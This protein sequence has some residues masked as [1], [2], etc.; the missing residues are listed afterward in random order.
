MADFPKTYLILAGLLLLLLAVGGPFYVQAQDIP[1]Q[2]ALPSA[3]AV[4]FEAALYLM[5]AFPALRERVPPLVTVLT[6]PLIY[7]LYSVPAEVFAARSCLLLLVMG[8]IATYWFRRLPPH[9]ASDLGFLILMAA[10]LAADI[11]KDIYARPHP[12][13]RLS[14]LG[15]MFWIR[16]GVLAVL[17]SRPQSGIAFGFLP[18]KE[19]WA[20]GLRWFA[21][22]LPVVLVG[23]TVSGFARFTPPQREWWQVAGIAV[24]YF[25]G[26]LWV[27]ALSEEFFF[28]GLLQQWVEAWTGSFPV[29][30]VF[31]ALSFG[32]VHLGFREFPNWPFA[33]LAAAAG[34]FYGL[35]FRAGRGIRPAMVTHALVVAVWK[36][37]FR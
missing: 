30:L 17:Q 8:A 26:V 4:F 9:P 7:A 36:T 25:L 22:A 23:S 5:L 32:A 19:D 11:F 14:I 27:V 29:A 3:A 33:A 31:A 28:R 2:A 18:R 10:P 6:G 37:W 21:I 12:V 16:A 24:G 35:A 20:V 15:Q 13:L 1:A 34:V